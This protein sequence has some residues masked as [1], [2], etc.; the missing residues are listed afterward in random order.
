MKKPKILHLLADLEIVN[1]SYNLKK[2]LFFA[3]NL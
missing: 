2:L 3:A 1:V